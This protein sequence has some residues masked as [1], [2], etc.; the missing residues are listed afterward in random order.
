MITV[1]SNSIAAGLYAA[2]SAN[3]KEGSITVNVGDTIN[4]IWSSGGADNATSTFTSSNDT[5]NWGSKPWVASLINGSKSDAVQSCQRG[6][7]YNINFQVKNS[8]TGATAQSNLMVKV[9]P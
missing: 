4:Y 6:G 5:C 3:G 9:N 1:G 2:L 7:I 8:Q